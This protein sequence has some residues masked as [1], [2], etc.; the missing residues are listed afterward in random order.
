MYFRRKET[1]LVS[2]SRWNKAAA[3]EGGGGGGGVFE[4]SET[5]KKLD[6]KPSYWPQGNSE[7]PAPNFFTKKIN[8]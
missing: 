1:F 2:S 3:S 7:T 6:V 4:T 8:K 5:E